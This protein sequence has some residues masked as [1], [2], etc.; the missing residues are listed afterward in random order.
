MSTYVRARRPSVSMVRASMEP[1]VTRVNEATMIPDGMHGTEQTYAT[2]TMIPDGMHATQMK[3][4]DLDRVKGPIEQHVWNQLTAKG[5]HPHRARAMVHRAA[6]R[7]RGF[8]PRSA[9]MHG[10][11]DVVADAMTWVT[12]GND[13][14]ERSKTGDV[15]AEAMKAAQNI[16]TFLGN[17][18]PELEA[19]S[20]ATVDAID[21][22]ADRLTKL[23][24]GKIHYDSVT[25]AF[26][27]ELG[28]AV[29]GE[30]MVGA[31]AVLD[32]PKKIVK[33]LGDEVIKPALDIVPWY[34]WAGAAV[35]GGA[36]AGKALKLW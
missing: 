26:F 5:V 27:D 28:N 36:V 4:Y 14:F 31:Q 15:S 34:V 33:F 23:A 20:S 18:G 6:G 32:T 13:I 19:A 29:R 2:V 17:R 35:A 11:G 21:Q 1:I 25:A 12:Y 7:V 22:T 24:T 10:L 16:N 8:R 30:V 9:G 3:V